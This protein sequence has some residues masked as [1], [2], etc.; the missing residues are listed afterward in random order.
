MKNSLEY[1]GLCF[2]LTSI[3]ACIGPLYEVIKKKK[4]G[5]TD[6]L[7]HALGI[8]STWV[9]FLIF[10]SIGSWA[11]SVAFSRGVNFGYWI[12]ETTKIPFILVLISPI[13]GVVLLGIIAGKIRKRQKSNNR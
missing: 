6:R 1:V 12:S 10:F 2:I 9:W 5:S 4:E 13:I 8:A 3:I 7:F 11:V